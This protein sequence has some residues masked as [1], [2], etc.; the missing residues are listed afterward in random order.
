VSIPDRGRAV[1]RPNERETGGIEMRLEGKDWVRAWIFE[2]KQLK[3][4]CR[5]RFCSK[6]RIVSDS[7]RSL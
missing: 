5:Y 4:Y 7:I 2:G 3:F 6:D 1:N